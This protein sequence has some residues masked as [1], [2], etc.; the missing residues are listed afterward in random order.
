MR[1]FQ[2]A[3][4]NWWNHRHFQ[5]H[6]K[7]NIF[8]KDPDVNM[9][10]IFVVGA[11]QPVE[12]R[13][14]KLIFL[15]PLYQTSIASKLLIVTLYPSLSQYGTKKIKRMPYN[16]QHQYFFLGMVIKSH[17]ER[18]KQTNFPGIIIMINISFSFSW[19]TTAYSGLFPHSDNSRHDLSP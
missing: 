18:M 2:G 9:L 14:T 5:H 12:A 17:S 6:A 7:P 3:S 8:S 19:T 4:A 10:R 11:T 15:T 1:V 16:R 13:C